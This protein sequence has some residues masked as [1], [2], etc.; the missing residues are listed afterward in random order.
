ME[1]T[2]EQLVQALDMAYARFDNAAKDYIEASIFAICE[3]ESRLDTYLKEV[4]LAELKKLG[5]AKNEVVQ[6][7][8]MCVEV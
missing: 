1:Q 8:E 6:E 5:E 2:H 4:K 7:E 3:A